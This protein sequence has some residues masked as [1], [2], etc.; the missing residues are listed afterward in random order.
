M[1]SQFRPGLRLLVT[2][3]DD[4]DYH[5][6]RILEYPVAPGEWVIRTPDG[7]E[8]AEEVSSW[9]DILVMSGRRVYPER[10]REV[11]AFEPPLDKA[12]LLELIRQGRLES[13]RLCAERGVEMP[14]EPPSA[15]DWDKG[16]MD[17][18]VRPWLEG[19]RARIIP[20]RRGA[21]RGGGAPTQ[22]RKPGTALGVGEVWVICDLLDDRF[23]S[24]VEATP[25]NTLAHHGKYLICRMDSHGGTACCKRM[26]TAEVAS[27]AESALKVLRPGPEPEPPKED[28]PGETP[29]GQWQRPGGTARTIW[30]AG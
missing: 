10:V 21:G 30:R 23:G 1:V 16:S 29:W 27:R 9:S 5:H 4:P 19:L 11:V 24:T 26:A 2:Y 17:M 22:K 6:E 28:D 13:D 14:T 3:D 18:P 15:V 20:V 12:E 7:D 25:E 8:Y